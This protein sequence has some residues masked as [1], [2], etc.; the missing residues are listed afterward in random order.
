MVINWRI[1][2]LSLLFLTLWASTASA[3]TVQA[4]ADR[5]RI[6]IGES[7]QLQLRIDSSPDSDPDLT[8]LQQ[9]WEILSRSQSSQMQIVN[10]SFS[11]SVV[12]S[13]TLMPRSRGELMIPAICIGENCSTPLPIEVSDRSVQSGNTDE[14]LLLEVEVSSQ[15]IV[16]Q[17]QLLFKV[18]LLR[19]VDLL[20]GQL[21]EPQPAGVEAVVKKLGDDRSYETRRNGQLYQVFERDYAIFPQGSGQ[22]RI[23]ALQFNG[24]I[25]SGRSRFDIYGQRGQR[26]RRTSQPVQGEVT[27]LPAELGRRPWIPATALELRDSWQQQVPKFTVGEPITRTLRLTAVGV[28]AAQLPELRPEVPDGFKSYPDQPNREDRHGSNGIKG[29]LIQKIALVPTRPGRYKFPAV[30]LDWWDVTQGQWQQARLESLTV[31]VAPG[32]STNL[33][34]SPPVENPTTRTSVLPDKSREPSSVADAAPKA[35]VSAGFWPWLSLGLMMGWLLTILLVLLS[36]KRQE[37]GEVSESKELSNDE[38]SAR[39]ATINAARNNNPQMTR[40]TMVQWSRVMWPDLPGFEYEQLCKVADSV[41]LK[42]LQAL[43]LCLYGGGSLPWNGQV[44]ADCIADWPQVNPEK[45]T[46][47]IP[48]LYPDNNGHL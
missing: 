19:R 37:V 44:L 16:A 33:T 45:E 1:F 15:E 41:L 32:T 27:A 40:Q 6:A 23:P 47:E 10:G 14:P 29:E 42:E 34:A 20:D 9:N 26:V 31:D 3:L 11:R 36:R 25:A 43:D 4:V 28:T 48:D 22:L 7:L 39:R 18:R 17:E 2:I 24:S 5:D 46:S 13:L 35:A 12:Y 21:S 8:P 38:K 30:E